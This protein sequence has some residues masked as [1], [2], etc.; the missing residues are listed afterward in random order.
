MQL[1][2]W[3]GWPAFASLLAVFWLMVDKPALW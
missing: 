2:F 3:L 1:W